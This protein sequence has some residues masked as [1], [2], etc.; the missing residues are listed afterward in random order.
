MTT[1]QQAAPRPDRRGD[2]LAPILKQRRALARWPLGAKLFDRAVGL[3]VPYA[4]T[5]KAQVLDLEPGYARVLMPD[6]RA[7][8]NHLRSIHA[9]ALINLGEMTAN[10]ALM[11]TQ[12]SGGRWIVTGLETKYVKKARGPIVALCRIEP[13]D[14]DWSL[15]RDWSG[16]V[17]LC[18][19][20]GDV[21]AR[22]LQ[23]WKIGPKRPR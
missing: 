13:S 15:D 6:R 16:E 14:L 20:S 1:A 17:T 18:D 9:V 7:V 3:Q 22:L 10:M 12:P 4:G 2:D 5:I 21:V 11:T 23:Y 8:R 19:S